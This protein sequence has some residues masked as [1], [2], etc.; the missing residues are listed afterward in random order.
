MTKKSKNIVQ[1]SWKNLNLPVSAF[2]LLTPLLFLGSLIAYLSLN[3]FNPIFLI[4]GFVF[5]VFTGLSITA[6]YHRLFAHRSYKANPLVK[7]LFLIGGSMAFASSA[8]KWSTNH[9]QHH[10]EVD[11]DLDPHNFHE[12]FWHAHLFW[13]LFDFP[14]RDYPKDLLNDKLVYW[15]DKLILP[16]GI[17]LN[18][19]AVLIFG[20]AFDSYLGALT[21][22]FLGR[23]VFNHHSM[24]FVNSIAHWMG[25]RTYDFN[26]T[27]TDNFVVA[28]LTFGEGYHNFHHT[29]QNDYRNGLR[30]WQYDPTKW[31]IKFLSYLNFTYSLRTTSDELILRMKLNAQQYTRKTKFMEQF[32]WLKEKGYFNF[33]LDEEIQ[34]LE[35]LKEKIKEAQR[36]YMEMKKEYALKKKEFKDAKDKRLQELRASLRISYEEFVIL[37]K[38][39]RFQ[40]NKIDRLVA[41]V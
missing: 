33:N 23:V 29:F 20:Y 25:K 4:L 3:E 22:I 8:L 14:T 21:F 41:A 32:Q 15:Q 11:T 35:P 38:E 19:L 36:H 31:L 40:I 30:W 18:T 17:G 1:Y 6:G 16:L 5:Y 13:L 7:L 2:L 28:L 9:R 26:Q 39:W 12:G 37:R 24:F 34:K 27:A 10:Q